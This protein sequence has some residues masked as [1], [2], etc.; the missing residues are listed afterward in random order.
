MS[1]TEALR[2]CY[3]DSIRGGDGEMGPECGA[4]E[5]SQTP[6]KRFGFGFNP[7]GAGLLFVKR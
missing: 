1:G 2:R 7:V 3:D 5:G 4:G 6:S